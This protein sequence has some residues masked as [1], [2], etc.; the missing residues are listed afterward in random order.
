MSERR[1]STAATT[2]SPNFATNNLSGYLMKKGEGRSAGRKKRDIAG[3]G[4]GGTVA[5]VVSSPD[6]LLSPHAASQR[7]WSRSGGRAA[8]GAL[9]RTSIVAAVH[10]GDCATMLD[11][12]ARLARVTHFDPRC[13][14]SCAVLCAALAFI[15]QGR[16]MN[17]SD[18]ARRLTEDA[19]QCGIGQLTADQA[20]DLRAHVFAPD[21]CEL[22]LDDPSAMGFTFK[23]LGAAFWAFHLFKGWQ[24]SVQAVIL[25]AGDADT[26]AAVAGALVGCRL[27]YSS[28]PKDMLL[29]LPHKA[30]LDKK[31]AAFLSA[32]LVS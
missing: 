11:N 8:N 25:E 19:V 1:A 15:L 6:F 31:V 20:A 23:T 3:V 27:G 9:M 10:F 22:H 18:E 12:C 26:N 16:T 2:R 30:W 29:A 32:V 5:S 7:V 28:L 4:L 14:A 13:V 21:L 17:S 24:E